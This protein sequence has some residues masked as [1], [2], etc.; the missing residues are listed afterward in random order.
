MD[1]R[2]LAQLFQDRLR[3]LLSANK[4]STAEFLRQAQIDRSALSQFLS[5]KS[6]R[7]PR[8]EMLRRIAT[9][10]GVSVDW[11]LGLENAPEG[12]QDYA[13]SLQ[14]EVSKL[15]NGLTPLQSWHAEAEGQKLRYVPSSLPDM[16]RLSWQDNDEN[17]EAMQR[18]ENADNILQPA[19]LQDM[20]LEIAMPL[21][22]LQDVS[23]KT[24]RWRNVALETRRAQLQLMAQICEEHYPAVRLHLFD[25]SKTFSAPFTVFGRRRAAIYVGDAYLVLT[26]PDQVRSFSLKFDALVRKTIISPD[27]AHET[28]AEL[29]QN[30]IE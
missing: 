6:D 2:I 27:K 29:A 11:L 26:A 18:K 1:K 3:S 19:S 13:P 10:S 5:P 14:V 4:S 23:E 24:G 21:Q 17:P 12:R 15:E 9:A 28:L 16:M 8:A 22:T 20:D 30:A 7:L 25:G